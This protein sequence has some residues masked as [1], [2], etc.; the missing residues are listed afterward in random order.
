[1]KFDLDDEQSEIRDMV[2]RF[3]EEEITPHAEL[4]DE[5]SYFPREVYR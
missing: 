3:T 4:W 2:R 1:M 5:E